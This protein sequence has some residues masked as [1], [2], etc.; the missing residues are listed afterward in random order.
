MVEAV[1]GLFL[2]GDERNPIRA[3]VLKL[4]V[5]AFALNGPAELT[6]EEGAI[7]VGGRDTPAN[8]QR[9]NR[10]AGALRS[11]SVEV[12]PG[13]RWDLMDAERGPVNRIG[14][15]R[16]WA[17]YWREREAA[18]QEKRPL[19]KSKKPIAFRFTGTLFRAV[20]NIDAKDGRGYD[21]GYWGTVARTVAG[22]E[23]ALA[24][25]PS[26]GK[27]KGGRTADLL[28]AVRRGGPGEAVFIPWW[29]VLRLSGER[30]GEDA[31]TR[32]AMGERYR[33]RVQML[34]DAGYVVSDNGPAPAGDTV[35]IVE[36]VRGS[37]REAGLRV[38]ASARFC[39]AVASGEQTRISATRLLNKDR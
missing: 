7:L 13:I 3:D 30:V 32:G 23:A 10:A 19:P 11:L 33:R 5:L 9:F 16:W 24:W 2:S 35:E 22:I 38:R 6:D 15:P 12:E 31:E 17:G 36:V 14:P 29:Q 25:G 34:Q 28:R 21:L 37:G 27:G 26:A 18:E 1:A 20:K 4:G 8:R 39:A